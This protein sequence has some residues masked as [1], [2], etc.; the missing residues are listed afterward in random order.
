MTLCIPPPS[1]PAPP[2]RTPVERRAG[3]VARAQVPLLLADLEPG[4]LLSV[5]GPGLL[6]FTPLP[7]LSQPPELPG[8][9]PGLGGSHR[10]CR[11]HYR[12]ATAAASKMQLQRTAAASLEPRH[13][14]LELINLIRP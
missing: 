4:R 12:A 13:P 10:L 7:A 14:H 9:L 2:P 8:R 1:P 5:G 3:K 11:H 6:G